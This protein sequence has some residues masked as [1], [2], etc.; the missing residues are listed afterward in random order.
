MSETSLNVCLPVMTRNHYNYYGRFFYDQMKVLWDER[1]LQLHHIMRPQLE[2]QH[3][4]R[5]QLKSSEV[6]PLPDCCFEVDIRYELTWM[7]HLNKSYICV[8]FVIDVIFFF[9]LK[10]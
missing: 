9:I 4:M 2:F 7:T 10:L 3:V 5:S 6:P 1:W 8:G